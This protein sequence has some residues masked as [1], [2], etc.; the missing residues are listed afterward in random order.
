MYEHTH[1]SPEMSKYKCLLFAASNFILSN[2]KEIT[3]T[4]S[5]YP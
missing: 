2:L 3:D 4:M 1:P 5:L